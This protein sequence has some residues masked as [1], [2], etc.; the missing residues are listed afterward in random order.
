M[1]FWT[2][3]E[4]NLLTNNLDQNTREIYLAYC[5]VY[6]STRSYD[7]IQKKVKQLRGD[8][9]T[10]TPETIV[11][12]DSGLEEAFASLLGGTPAQGLMIPEVSAQQKKEKREKARD[13]LKD[14][15]EYGQSLNIQIPHRPRV[16]EGTSLC[17]LI[18]D[19]H[20]GK[21]TDEF[22]LNT[23]TSRF[24]EIPT[25]LHSRVTEEINEIVVCLIG[26]LVEGEDVYPTQ[27]N[28][29]ECSAIEQVQR[30]VEGLWDMIL[31]LRTLF[32]CRVT[33]HSVPGNHGRVSKTANEKTN[34]D[35]VVYYVLETI[36]AT[37]NDPNITFKANYNE[38]YTFHIQDKVGMLYHYGVK[39]TG[40]PAMREKVAGWGT[41]KN[42]DFM[43]H[44][45]WHEWHVGAWLGKPV[46]ANGCMCGPDDLAQ[47]IAREDSARQAYFKVRANEPLYDFGWLEW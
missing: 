35:N 9:L 12:D 18:S 8:Q 15:V 34:W 30:C 31:N 20:V 46:I 2:E 33:I 39:H 43:C 11:E 23:A 47:R 21:H 6:G 16:T 10:V 36:V 14:L 25:R 44:G 17:L 5:D 7:S 27:A 26:D 4:T 41:V 3:Q 28:H 22:N 29:I 38:F 45:H 13:W 1:K 24:K 32:Q 40:T 19:T 37:H 42:F